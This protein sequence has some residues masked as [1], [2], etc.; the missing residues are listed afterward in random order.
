VEPPGMRANDQHIANYLLVIREEKI[1]TDI[2]S[3]LSVMAWAI[4]IALLPLAAMGQ[5]TTLVAVNP[6]QVLESNLE[7]ALVQNGCEVSQYQY[8]KDAGLRNVPCWDPRV[9]YTQPYRYLGAHHDQASICIHVSEK[10]RP[11]SPVY[12]HIDLLCTPSVY[13]EEFRLLWEHSRG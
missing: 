7:Q 12:D 11:N 5:V 6:Q 2:T 4:C 1:V 13:K 9:E 8:I 10:Q 3:R